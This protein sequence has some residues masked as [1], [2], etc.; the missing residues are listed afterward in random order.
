M[1]LSLGAPYKSISSFSPISLPGFAV[2]TGVNGSGK[3]QLLEAIANG[4]IS[5]EGVRASQV[6]RF[7]LADFG[8]SKVELSRYITTL[9]DHFGEAFARFKKDIEGFAKLRAL[10]GDTWQHVVKECEHRRL[11]PDLLEEESIKDLTDCGIIPANAVNAWRG[12]TSHVSKRLYAIRQQN[13][14]AAEL[15]SPSL[16]NS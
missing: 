14:K 15:L 7:T 13:P 8:V 6:R 16:R 11:C 10:V 9:P 4:H 12:Y 3:T 2:V 1:F 5:I